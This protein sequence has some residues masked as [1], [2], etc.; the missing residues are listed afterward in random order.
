MSLY[1][2][3]TARAVHLKFHDVIRRV[4][5]GKTFRMTSD[6]GEKQTPALSSLDMA[7]CA[8]E[9]WRVPK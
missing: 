5:D 4:R 1:T 9:E 6:N 8:A 3:T 7:M 2:V